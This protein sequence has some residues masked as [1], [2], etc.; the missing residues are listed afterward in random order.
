MN[1]ES[2]NLYI[3]ELI[4]KLKVGYSTASKFLISNS[5]SLYL[6]LITSGIVIFFRDTLLDIYTSFVV[7][8]IL[9][10]YQEGALSDL[11]IILGLSIWL[12]KSISKIKRAYNGLLNI[13]LL[14]IISITSVFYLL[15][16]IRSQVYIYKHSAF[17]PK[18]TIADVVFSTAI[19][20]SATSIIK[21]SL[22]IWK[23]EKKLLTNNQTEPIL[24]INDDKLYRNE[25]ARAI[26]KSIINQKGLKHSFAIGIAGKWGEGKTS[27]VNLI[28]ANLKDE[29]DVLFIDFL[30]WYS[31]N[32]KALIFDFFSTLKKNLKQHNPQIDSS[33]KDYTEL[34]LK[35]YDKNQSLTSIFNSLLLS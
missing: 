19:I 23:K 25:Y 17:F 4:D 24:E 3:N 31:S 5:T 29:N 14:M 26:A 12:F 13:Y 33:L 27:F 11:L 2:V 32:A 6:L 10:H 9:S 30:P 34:L 20:I 18:L 16:R 8:P 35:F 7:T 21:F 28:K 15:V 1:K 22:Y